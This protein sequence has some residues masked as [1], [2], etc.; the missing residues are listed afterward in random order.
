MG[1]RLHL[2]SHF[3]HS[4]VAFGGKTEGIEGASV[5]RLVAVGGDDRI[6]LRVE[7]LLARGAR[8]QERRGLLDLHDSRV[9][10]LEAEECAATTQV[11]DNRSGVVEVVAARPHTG[12]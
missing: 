8:M 1:C 12:R 10:A 6:E 2:T 4:Q 5:L 11:A 3:A 9:G 7:L